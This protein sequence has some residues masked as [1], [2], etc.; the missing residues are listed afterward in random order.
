M[1]DPPSA[2]VIESSDNAGVAVTTI[3]ALEA[4]KI[5]PAHTVTYASRAGITHPASADSEKDQ[6]ALGFGR[7]TAKELC[8]AVIK[9]I[10]FKEEVIVQGAL[11]DRALQRLV[12]LLLQNRFLKLS[13][14]FPF[15]VILNNVE[16]SI[17]YEGIA[18]RLTWSELCTE[19]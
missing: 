8:H 4:L 13:F 6:S 9:A 12:P 5:S 17:P 14:C 15:P 10:F 1:N 18:I 11:I 19:L 3:F 16:F 7:K 2:P